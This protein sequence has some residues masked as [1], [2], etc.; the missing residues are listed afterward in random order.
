MTGSEDKLKL[1]LAAGVIA[2]ASIKYLHVIF[3]SQEK[4]FHFSIIAMLAFGGVQ[5]HT[6]YLNQ[7]QI[8]AKID[9]LKLRQS[10]ASRNSS[11]ASSSTADPKNSD[12]NSKSKP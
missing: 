4:W 6:F 2:L 5:L 7:K 1:A 9:G 11:E 3:Y 10:S 12:T 8:E